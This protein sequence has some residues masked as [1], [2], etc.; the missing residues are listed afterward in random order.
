LYL[1][2]AS[3]I[4]KQGV[5][6]STGISDNIIHIYKLRHL[7]LPHRFRANKNGLADEG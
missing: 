7:S 1:S 6:K 3:K 4:T 5:D 2:L